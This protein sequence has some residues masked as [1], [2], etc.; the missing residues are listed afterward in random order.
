M[1]YDSQ[2]ALKRDDQ[3]PV[4]PTPQSLSTATPL[5]AFCGAELR[6]DPVMKPVRSLNA[7]DQINAAIDQWAE[8]LVAIIEASENPEASLLRAHEAIASKH[9]ELE[10]MA[11]RE[12]E[13]RY[14][15]SGVLHG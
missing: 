13:S 9:K 2:G 5:L 3:N 14:Q 12:L 1:N 8:S 7:R 11:W 6:K 15:P 4:T 10:T